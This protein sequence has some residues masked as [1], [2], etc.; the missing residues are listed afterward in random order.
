LTCSAESAMFSA[1]TVYC[2]Y[3]RSA[4]ASTVFIRPLWRPNY[5]IASDIATLAL[6]PGKL[7]AMLFRICA[8]VYLGVL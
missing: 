2:R 1:V 4:S 6:Q 5:S 3:F 7:L 8:V